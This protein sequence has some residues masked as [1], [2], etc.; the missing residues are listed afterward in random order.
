MVRDFCICDKHHN[1]AGSPSADVGDDT[2]WRSDHLANVALAKT[3]NLKRG[4][5]NNGDASLTLNL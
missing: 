3:G 5:A 1:R 4:V 2:N